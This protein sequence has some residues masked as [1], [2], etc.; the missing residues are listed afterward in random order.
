MKRCPTCQRGYADETLSFCLE[1][2]ALLL[3]DVDGAATIS[4]PNATIPASPSFHR[5]NSPTEVL[6][7]GSVESETKPRS[8]PTIAQEPRVTEREMYGEARTAPPATAHNTT[9]VVGLTIIATLI[10]I[11][12]GGVGAWFLFKGDKSAG[13]T[14]TELNQNQDQ[15][16]QPPVVNGN[17][18]KSASP[19]PGASPAATATPTAPQVDVAAVREQVTSAL[20][21][22]TSASRAHD[23]DGHM[24]YYADTLD[25]YYNASNVSSSRVR[26]D[27]SRAYALYST[28]DI[29]LS[30]VKVTAE[31]SG[32]SATAVFDKTWTF[33]GSEKYSSGSVHQKIWLK[34]LG[35]R[36]R[37]TGE[38][39]LQV[40]YVNRAR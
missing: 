16:P 36:W 17:L 39:D 6:G 20:N 26:S 3:G 40:Y 35:G 7:S 31:P 28:L 4:D 27:R 32:D 23:L 29:E 24:A 14:K 11:A 15:G 1:D 38:K 10:L 18:N 21:G 5:S 9:L 34:K 30:N 8:Q 13:P 33:E 22:W 2:G 25:T 19:D 12:L 37:I